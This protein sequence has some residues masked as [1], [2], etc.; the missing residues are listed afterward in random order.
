MDI[1]FTRFE[2]TYKI[3]SFI[4]EDSTGKCWK[5]RKQKDGVDYALKITKLPKGT[6]RK[7]EIMKEKEYLRTLGHDNIIQCVHFTTVTKESQG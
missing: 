7:N 6:K 1:T 4:G 3:G 5:V 2:E